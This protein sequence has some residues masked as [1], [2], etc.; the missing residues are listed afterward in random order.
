MR[1]GVWAILPLFAF[2]NQTTSNHYPFVTRHV[3]RHSPV[4]PF[5]L[6]RNFAVSPHRKEPM[7]I[8]PLLPF[9]N[10]TTFTL[11]FCD[12][13][14]VP[15]L[16]ITTFITPIITLSICSTPCPFPVAPIPFLS[17][18]YSLYDCR[19]IIWSIPSPLPLPLYQVNSLPYLLSLRVQYTPH[20]LRI[21]LGKERGNIVYYYYYPIWANCLSVNHF[22]RSLL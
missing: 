13:P 22:P 7:T 20:S 19:P 11:T 12:Y 1:K 6:A 5:L 2:E 4:T 9:E 21:T 15:Y 18:P 16:S 3:T 10:P 17:L 8:R 14:D